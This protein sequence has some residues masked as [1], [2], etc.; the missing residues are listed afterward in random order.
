MSVFFQ[1][2][3]CITGVRSG[4]LYLMAL[5][6]KLYRMLSRYGFTVRI[7]S[8]CA[9]SE[10]ITACALAISRSSIPRIFETSVAKVNHGK[11]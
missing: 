9:K 6:I 2:C 3:T 5:L 8:A 1:C 4:S 11:F 10:V 7:V